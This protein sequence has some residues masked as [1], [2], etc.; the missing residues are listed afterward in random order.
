MA[1][2]SM[3]QRYL[4]TAVLGMMLA[5]YGGGAWGRGGE[6]PPGFQQGP[7]YPPGA[8]YP[9]DLGRPLGGGRQAE[10]MFPERQ[11]AGDAARRRMTPEE[12]RQLR[13]DI[14]DAGRNIYPERPRRPGR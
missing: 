9:G 3:R 6:Q 7:L 2:F 4:G 12:R 13:Q 1:D 11:D 14:Y 5:L 8:G 10:P